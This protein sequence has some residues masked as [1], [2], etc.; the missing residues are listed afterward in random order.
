MEKDPGNVSSYIT[1]GQSEVLNSHE[2]K[3]DIWPTIAEDD[4]QF[5]QMDWNV[6]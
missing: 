2:T 4:D 6:Y 5:W 3:S 1:L